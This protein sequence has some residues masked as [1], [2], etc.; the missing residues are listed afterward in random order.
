LSSS[1]EPIARLGRPH[2]LEGYLGLYVDPDD[3]DLFRVGATVLAGDLSLTIRA[4]RPGKKGPQIAF[5]E[6]TD[7]EGAEQIRNEDLRLPEVTR[8]LGTADYWVD[9]LIGLE[10][11]PGGGVVV[12]IERGPAQDRLLVERRGVTFEVPFVHALV[13]VVD[14]DG[15]YVVIEEIEGLEG[16]NPPSA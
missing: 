11:R 15:G 8:G 3:L 16:V 9:D 10:V 4:I 7:R 13:P 1:T 14:I 2:G 12:G 6:I 5:G